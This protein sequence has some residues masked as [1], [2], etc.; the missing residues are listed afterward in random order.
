MSKYRYWNKPIGRLLFGSGV[1]DSW[2]L[3]FSY[4]HYSRSVSIEFLHWYVFIEY[5]NKEEVQ[6]YKERIKSEKEKKC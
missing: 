5:W 2:G 4:C 3:G 6:Q 1:W